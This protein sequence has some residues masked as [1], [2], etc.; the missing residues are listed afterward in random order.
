MLISEN[1]KQ[2]THVIKKKKKQVKDHNLV[3]IKNEH[4]R[5]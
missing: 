2:V 5:N 3:E 4:I 1:S